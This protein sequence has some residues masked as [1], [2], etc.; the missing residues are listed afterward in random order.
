MNIYP[1]SNQYNHSILQNLGFALQSINDADKEFSIEETVRAISEVVPA[2]SIAD[3]ERYYGLGSK[4]QGL[5]KMKRARCDIENALKELNRAIDSI[6][7]SE[8]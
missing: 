1:K 3:V 4:K 8:K 5:L 7:A 2:G 6:E